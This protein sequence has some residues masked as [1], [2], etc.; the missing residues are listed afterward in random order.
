MVFEINRILCV[1][2]KIFGTSGLQFFDIILSKRNVRCKAY[3][4]A[5]FELNYFN[6]S[7]R[8][9]DAAV[10]RSQCF[11]CKQSEGYGAVSTDAEKLIGFDDFFKA[12]L[13]FLAFVVERRRYIGDLDILTGINNL[14]GLFTGKQHSVGALHL[15]NSV[16]A[17]IQSLA[18]CLAGCRSDNSVHDVTLFG[19]YRAVRSNNVFRRDDIKLRAGKTCD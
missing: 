1:V 6:Q 4:A 13:H 17:E 3:R 7:V 11:P 2:R 5:D 19:S 15:N 10:R 16:F 14:N 8:R 12:D 9:N 18:L